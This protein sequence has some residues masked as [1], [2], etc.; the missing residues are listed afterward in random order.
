MSNTVHA[1]EGLKVEPTTS[2]KMDT[3]LEHT[4]PK[5]SESS[6]LSCSSSSDSIDDGSC[7]HKKIL[8]QGNYDTC[9]SCGAYVPKV[10]FLFD[11]NDKLIWN[12]EWCQEFQ[13][14]QGYLLNSFPSQDYLWDYD[15][16]ICCFQSN[17]Q[18]WIHSSKYNFSW[19]QL[20]IA[21]K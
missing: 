9:I 10:H 3:S 7:H 14:C 21:I 5:Q 20:L 1:L 8:S 6:N 18:S 17:P 15:Q 12:I 16:K 13:E 2:I 11:S 19:W 4:L